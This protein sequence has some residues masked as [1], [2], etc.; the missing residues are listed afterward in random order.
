MAFSS[1]KNLYEKLGKYI[2]MNQYNV[3]VNTFV[4]KKCL[5]FLIYEGE[6]MG[7]ASYLVKKRADENNNK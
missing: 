1:F 6:C 3:L 5:V 2:I 4:I 7:I